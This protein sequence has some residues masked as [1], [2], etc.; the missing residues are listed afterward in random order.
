LLEHFQWLTA[1]QSEK[2][3]ESDL[4]KVRMVVADVKREAVREVFGS[5]L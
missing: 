3:S 4:A 1:E 5:T 2:L